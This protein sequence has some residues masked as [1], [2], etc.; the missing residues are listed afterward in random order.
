LLIYLPHPR[1]QAADYS[2]TSFFL[3]FPCL[4]TNSTMYIPGRSFEISRVLF[5]GSHKGPFSR[6]G[7]C[8]RRHCIFIIFS[9]VPSPALLT[10]VKKYKPFFSIEEGISVCPDGR[11]SSLRTSCPVNE[12]MVT[13]L[14]S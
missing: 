8:F 10:V 6:F 3:T 7:R 9:V 13:L 5:T 4:V 2:T 11:F 14:N 1:N 12:L